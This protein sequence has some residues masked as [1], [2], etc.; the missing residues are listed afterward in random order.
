MAK[1]AFYA[2]PSAGV[3]SLE[4]LKQEQSLDTVLDPIPRSETIQQ[5]SVL[6]PVLAAV[7]PAEG[8][9][10]IC[11][12]GRVVLQRMLDQILEPQPEQVPGILTDEALNLDWLNDMPPH[13]AAQN[14][15]AFMEW[16]S[17]DWLAGIQ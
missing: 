7:G 16:L 14:D 12:Q 10:A 8:N 4:L 1:L 5:L 13:V 9:H 11:A 2:V 17:S 3:L 6:I 15:R